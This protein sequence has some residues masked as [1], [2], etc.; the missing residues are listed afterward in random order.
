MAIKKQHR[1]RHQNIHQHVIYIV[2]NFS[3]LLYPFVK[4]VSCVCL[5]WIELCDPL[6]SVLELQL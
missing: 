1:E 6:A 3:F 2:G 4:S 5:G